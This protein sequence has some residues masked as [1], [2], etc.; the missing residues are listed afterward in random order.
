MR[1]RDTPRMTSREERVKGLIRV[2][3]QELTGEDEAEVD[4]Y[5]APDF[6][7]HGPDGAELDYAG[8]RGYFT[9][10]R[11]AFDDLAISRGIVVAEGDYV[12]CQTTITGIFVREFTQSPVG[13]LPPNGSRVVFELTNIFRYDEQG[14]LAEEWVQTDNRSRLR[15]LGAEGR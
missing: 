2:G 12:A 6:R 15:H 10:L 7:F 4:A 5:F 13:P 11:A 9:A 8:L 14:R 3:E 1:P